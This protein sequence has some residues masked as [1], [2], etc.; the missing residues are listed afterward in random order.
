M[1]KWHV[2]PLRFAPAFRALGVCEHIWLRYKNFEPGCFYPLQKWGLT[3][4]FDP[5]PSTYFRPPE[6]A[7]TAYAPHYDISGSWHIYSL[8]WNGVGLILWSL[9]LKF[10]S[11]LTRR[12]DWA[13]WFWAKWL[14]TL[15]S[16]FEVWSFQASLR[17]TE[18]FEPSKGLTELVSVCEVDRFQFFFSQAF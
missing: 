15:C 10:L 5:V 18:F 6:R 11:Q 14:V 12:K 16:H 17:L 7:Y 4:I 3:L 13:K 8:S 1:A 2:A 9:G